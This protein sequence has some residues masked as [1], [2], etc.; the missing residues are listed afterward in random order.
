MIVGCG[1]TGL[2]RFSFM[3]MAFG[4]TEA[5]DTLLRCFG[6]VIHVFQYTLF[7]RLARSRW[8]DGTCV[9]ATLADARAGPAEQGHQEPQGD[10]TTCSCNA[11]AKA[12]E[13]V[14]YLC[15]S[16]PFFADNAGRFTLWCR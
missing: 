3:S 16:R 7:Y 13:P 8:M 6:N 14:S 12:G 9:S 2:H 1:C 5:R 15:G 11:Q 10:T 4:I